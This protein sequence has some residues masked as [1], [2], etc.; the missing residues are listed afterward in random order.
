MSI[1]KI[2]LGGT[3][4]VLLV[5]STK[6][7]QG[8]CLREKILRQSLPVRWCIYIGIILYILVFG[9]YGYGYSAQ[10]FIYGGF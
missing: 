8:C 1:E 3:L 7:E 4:V 2:A 10:A 5:V 6:Q 9:T